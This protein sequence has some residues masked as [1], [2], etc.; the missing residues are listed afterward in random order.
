MKGCL[1]FAPIVI[2][3]SLITT[4]AS[5]SPKQAKPDTPWEELRND[6]SSPD[7]LNLPSVSD[8]KMQ[9]LDPMVF[10]E[11]FSSDPFKLYGYDIGY[12]PAG[13]KCPLLVNRTILNTILITSALTFRSF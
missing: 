2:L 8:W 13:G 10:T 9:C 6:L 11:P 12:T 7:I 4:L 1:L 3:R 5:Q